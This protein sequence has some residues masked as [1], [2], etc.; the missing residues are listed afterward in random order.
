MRLLTVREVSEMTGLSR[1]SIYAMV[2][3]GDF[4]GHSGETDHL[5]RRKSITCSGANRSPVPVKPITCS[6]ANRSPVGAKRRGNSS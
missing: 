1:S 5:F 6:G 2:A 4:P 3:A